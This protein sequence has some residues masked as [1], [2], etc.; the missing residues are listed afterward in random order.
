[1][2][3][4][5]CTIGGLAKWRARHLASTGSFYYINQANAI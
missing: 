1:M 2:I 5:Q 3:F 4:H